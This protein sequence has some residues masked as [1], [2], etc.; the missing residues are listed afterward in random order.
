MKKK[1]LFQLLSLCLLFFLYSCGENA[2][3]ALSDESSQEACR[4]ETTKNLDSGNWDA[5][6]NSSCAD[7]MQ[8]GAAYFGRAG[9]DIKDVINRLSEAKDEENDLDI[10]L[11]ALVPKVTE[12]SL[13]D[14]SQAKTEYTMVSEDDPHYKDAQF[15][16]SLVDTAYSLSLMKV[17][18]DADGDGAIS[19]CDINW[20]GVP[21][22]ADAIACALMASAN[23]ND[24]GQL[25]Y[26]CGFASSIIESQDITFEGKSGIY[27]GMTVS[28]NNNNPTSG[29]DTTYKKVLYLDASSKYWLVTTTSEKCVG[30]D[31]QEWPCPVEQDGEPLDFV[32]AI[33][34]SINSV[35]VSLG[36]AIPADEMNDVK[37]AI[38]EIRNEACKKDGDPECTSSE[39]A[40][41][42]QNNLT[43]Q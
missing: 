21:D 12:Q 24:T 4:Y 3:K 8:K 32:T 20:N 40:D 29:C 14:L 39:I 30:S 10:Y 18:I 33:D 27:R 25:S 15:Y 37:A 13:N 34:N 43:T 42:I 6:I 38:E 36:N 22:D 35:L 11:K 16:I 28:I 2:F 31:R 1:R 41:Y 9:F 7:S 17:V 5:V 23:F 26:D 19:Q